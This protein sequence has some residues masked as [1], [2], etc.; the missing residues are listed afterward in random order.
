MDVFIN[1]NINKFM[2][3]GEYENYKIL[4]HITKLEY[5]KSILKNNFDITKSK[6]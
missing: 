6:K 1:Q 3:K 4:Y 2:K 5:A